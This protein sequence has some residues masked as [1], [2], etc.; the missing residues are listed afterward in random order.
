[1][2]YICSFFLFVFCV[3]ASSQVIVLNSAPVTGSVCY[4]DGTL[5]VNVSGGTQPYQYSLISG[6]VLA[7]VTYPIYPDSANYFASLHS[8]SYT[9]QVSDNAGHTSTFTVVIPGNYQFPVLSSSVSS[10]KITVTASQGRSPYTYAISSASPNGPFGGYRVGNVFDSL[11][12]GTYYVRVIDSCGNFYTTAPIVINQLPL[13]ILA[14][15]IGNGGN[16]LVTAFIPSAVFGNPP[17]TYTCYNNGFT[18]TNTNGQFSVPSAY[19]CPD[20][21]IAVDICGDTAF[22]VTD[23]HPLILGL[24]SNFTDSTATVTVSGG[25]PPYIYHFGQGGNIILTQNNGNF[26]HL[27]YVSIG[28]DVVFDVIDACGR[29]KSVS[30][31]Y[32]NFIVDNDCPFNG[33]LYVPQPIPGAIGA[34]VITCLNCIPMQTL[35]ASQ[36]YFT[37]LDTGSYIIKVTDA[38]GETKQDTFHIPD[39]KP[40]SAD[41]EFISCNDVKAVAIVG[42][43]PVSSGIVYTLY[44]NSNDSLAQNSTGLFGNL[45]G[46]IYTINVHADYCIDVQLQF[47]IPHFNGFCITPYMDATCQLHVIAKYIGEDLPEKYSLV[48]VPGGISYNEVPPDSGNGIFF[49][50]PPGDYTLISDSGCSVSQNLNYYFGLTET[51]NTNCVNKGTI[52]LQQLNINFSVCAN[53]YYYTLEYLN[54]GHLDTAYGYPSTI[55]FTGLDTGTYIARVYLNYDTVGFA[56]TIL[57]THNS[58]C[59]I[60]SAVIIISPHV[61]PTVNAQ[62]ATVCGQ[63]DS[64]DVTFTITGGLPPYYL[65]IPGYASLTTDSAKGV[66]S[67]IP[68]GNYTLI[69]SDSCGISSSLSVTVIDSCID[70]SAVQAKFSV[71]DSLPCTGDTVY[72]VGVGS[73]NLSYEWLLNGISVSDSLLLYVPVDSNTNATVS[74][75]VHNY[76]CFDTV[77]VLIH[78]PETPLFY[79]GNDTVLCDGYKL[80]LNTGSN[81]T[82][83]STGAVSAAI[84][85]ADSGLYWAMVTGKCSSFSDSI[86][87]DFEMCPSV[88]HIPDA[89]TP[90][91]DGVNDFF[92]V[93]GTSIAEWEIRIYNRWGELVY[94]STNT[95]ELNE[96]S[97]GWDGRFRGNLQT[98]ATFVYYVSALGTDGKKFFE[99]GNL[100]LI[101]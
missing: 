47:F 80:S 33:N 70:C 75:I 6:P 89:F 41:L 60:D 54:T 56:G 96:L 64:A 36:P 74:F 27:P 13:Q 101:R 12:N 30:D 61:V 78:V 18:I 85:V 35:S 99:K 65:T 19:Q 50:V 66:L 82:N 93:F 55:V 17:V 16:D 84:Q 31:I 43:L 52:V 45:A 42:G 63:N 23:C 76:A 69:V 53:K 39:P 91:G 11:C 87:I 26:T 97:M 51:H 71:S 5:R 81:Q 92:T 72:F 14:T 2:K 100:T 34:A 57:N 58:S 24:C 79:L 94:S 90:N 25:T 22:A 1:M 37:N 73:A 28:S 62:N 48:S 29:R 7:N 4:N 32:M 44:N 10:S 77:S 49:D 46:G 88:L 83:W 3:R 95:A 40:I 98:T 86:Q 9:L 21:I 15:C 38:C 20:T 8:G 68:L 59:A 67:G